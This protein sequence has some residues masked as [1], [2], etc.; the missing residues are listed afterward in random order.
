MK[1]PSAPTF[2]T[3]ADMKLTAAVNVAICKVVESSTRSSRRIAWSITP[4]TATARLI[5][6]TEA[7]MTIT[8]LAKP[9]NAFF[10]GTTPVR[11]AADRAIAATRS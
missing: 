2:L 11:M 1:T 7:M 4:E 6:S 9:S 3:N 5:T 10:A 8:G